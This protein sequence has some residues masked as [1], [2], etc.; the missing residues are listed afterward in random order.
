MLLLIDCDGILANYSKFF[1][2]HLNLFNSYNNRPTDYTPD[3]ITGW[4][5]YDSLPEIEKES[6]KEV[7]E[8]IGKNAKHIPFIPG[9]IEG[10][11]RLKQKHDIVIVTTPSYSS[12]TWTS[13][14]AKWLYKNFAIKDKDIIYTARKELVDGD[15]FIDDSVENVLKWYDKHNNKNKTPVLFDQPSNRILDDLQEDRRILANSFRIKGWDNLIKKIDFLD[16]A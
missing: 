15:V 13:D 11:K 7:R 16:S 14:R 5:I 3:Q 10:I 12:D 9:A 1:L 4:H 6:K 8:F 2:D